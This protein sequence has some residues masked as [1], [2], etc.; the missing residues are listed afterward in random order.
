MILIQKNPNQN[1]LTK[2]KEKI[3]HWQ[4]LHKKVSL[5]KATMDKIEKIGNEVVAF[6]DKKIKMARNL[7]D[8]N[9]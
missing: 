7:K 6:Y 2:R 5:N 4:K 1:L 9:L 8:K 3:L